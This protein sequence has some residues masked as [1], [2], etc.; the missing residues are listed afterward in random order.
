MR[1]ILSVLLENESGALSRVI[2]LFSQRNYNIKSVTVAPTD[3]LSISHM[4]I[5]T[6]GETKVIEQIEKQ[7]NKLIDVLKVVEI[8]DST[9][10]Q[11]EIMLV[12]IQINDQTK[13]DIYRINN[14][15]KGKIINVTHC[16]YIIQI[17]GSSNK[18]DVF[19]D[20]VKSI[21]KIIDI[22]RSGVVGITIK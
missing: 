18:L 1:K 6:I 19:L 16:N 2:G 11:I 14:I 15:F 4:I 9:H 7:L 10:K 20:L 21:S 12:K 5:E 8:N 17:V 13:T 3:D 22:A